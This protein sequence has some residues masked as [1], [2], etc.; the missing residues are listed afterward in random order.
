MTVRSM[1]MTINARFGSTRARTWRLLTSWKRYGFNRAMFAH[2]K[3]TSVQRTEVAAVWRFSTTSAIELAMV[4]GLQRVP[5][6][7]DLLC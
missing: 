2:L 5:I 3:E 7:F 1:N 6:P 4:P